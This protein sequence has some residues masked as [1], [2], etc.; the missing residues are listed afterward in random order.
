MDT[1]LLTEI[2]NSINPNNE[3]DSLNPLIDQCYSF[4]QSNINE[5][6]SNEHKTYLN[7]VLRFYTFEK[8][9]VSSSF[10]RWQ[11]WLLIDQNI[12][13]RVLLRRIFQFR[14]KQERLSYMA[15]IKK[16]DLVL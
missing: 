1:P 4:L 12:I 14:L 8:K 13:Q 6:P 15:M 10:T 16:V 2:K 5:Y 3:D 7:E 9:D 11:K